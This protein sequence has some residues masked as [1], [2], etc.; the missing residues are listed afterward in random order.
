MVQIP[1]Q[2]I[3]ERMNVT[4]KENATVVLECNATGVP[5]PKVEWFKEPSVKIVGGGTSKISICQEQK[6]T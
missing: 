3:P 4:V 2:I 5:E 6:S 1:P